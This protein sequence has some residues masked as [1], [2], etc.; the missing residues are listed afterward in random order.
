MQYIPYPDADTANARSQAMWNAVKGPGARLGDVTQYLYGIR[1]RTG[2][3]ELDEG[4]PDGVDAALVVAA[5]D[6]KLD[7]LIQRR[8]LTATEMRP[9]MGLYP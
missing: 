1:A 2:D 6:A 3:A 8:T 5:R 9:L 4:L 7:T